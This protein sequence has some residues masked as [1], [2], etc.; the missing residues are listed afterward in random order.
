M[1]IREKSFDV[2]NTDS[3]LYFADGQ[4]LFKANIFALDLEIYEDAF[5]FC[6]TNHCWKTSD[7]TL[8]QGTG[9]E[10][11]EIENA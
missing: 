2:R 10:R 5:T 8:F 7:I 1:M 9:K 3:R 6:E 11:K 4:S